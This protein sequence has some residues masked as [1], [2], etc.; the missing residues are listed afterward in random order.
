IEG[1]LNHCYLRGPAAGPDYKDITHS[2]RVIV[3]N[4]DERDPM[5]SHWMYK[6]LMI[7]NGWDWFDPIRN[8]PRYAACIKRMEAFITEGVWNPEG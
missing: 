3:Y 5:W 6:P 4:T 7:Q 2:A 1:V 8:D